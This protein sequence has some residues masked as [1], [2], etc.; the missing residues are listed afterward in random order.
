MTKTGLGVSGF[1]YEGGPRAKECRQ[2]LEAGKGYYY[3]YY[4]Y[5]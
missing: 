1:E 2:P 4:Y 5:Y 3:Y